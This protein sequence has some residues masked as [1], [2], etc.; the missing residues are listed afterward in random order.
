M[1]TTINNLLLASAF[2]ASM[3][4]CSDFLDK[5]PLSQGTEAIAFQNPSQFQQAA[6]RF[7]EHLPG[8]DYGSMD[9]G[10]DIAGLGSNGGGSAPESNGT[11]GGSYGNIR[12]YNILLEKAEAFKGDKSAL[13]SSVGMAYFFRG[14]A[15][16]NLLRAFGGVPVITDV[17]KITDESLYG[18]RKSRYEVFGQVLS[19]LR[20]A[21]ELLPKESSI[22]NADKGRIS[23]EAA[24]AYLGRVLLYE[25]TWEKYVPS[26]G[27]DLDGDGVEAGAGKAKPS[28]YPSVTDMLTES[29]DMSKA[30]MDEAQ[31]HGTYA[32]WNE[33]DSLSY[34][35]LFSI[36]ETNGNISN[37]KN[38]GK[39]TNKEFIIRRKYDYVLK[40]SRKNITHTVA[41]GQAVQISTQFGE[42]FLCRNGLP[43]RISYTGNM[44]DAQ[45]NPEFSGWGTFIGEFRNR[46]YR[47]IGCTG[48]PD[49]VSWSGRSEDGRQCTVIGQPYPT[50]LFPKNNDKYDP[51]DPVYSSKVAVFRPYLRGGGTFSGYG[52]RKYLPEGA[53]R[54]DYTESADWPILRLA[55]VYLNYAEAVC[56]L[57]NGQ[58]SDQDLDISINKL[59]DRARVAHLTNALIA[60]VW[61]AGWWDHKTNRTVCH[62]MTMLDEIRRERACE[63]FGEGFRMDDLKRWGIAHINLRGLKLGRHVLNTAYTK[64]TCNDATYFGQPCYDPDNAPLRYGLYTGSGS[65]DPDYG[66]SIATVADNLQ[67]LQRDYLSAIPLQQIRLNN[68]LI[69]NP[70]W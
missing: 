31:S 12:Q 17:L 18:P 6:D 41:T 65:N 24:Q 27:Y 19:D 66:R 62:K 53:G 52:S 25:A 9:R 22:A 1:K 23:K 37:F 39:S 11:W 61:D 51:T 35:Y 68:S 63:L 70:G 46:D 40:Q 42:S 2:I 28:G 64:Y 59:R 3:A 4:S 43:L 13:N 55:E 7:I 50:P 14:M 38:V 10:T 69:Q 33:C 26:I 44:S 20:R 45:N 60:N 32:L 49:R 34:Y 29:R 47:F 48:V 15:Y 58:I 21:V 67:Y 16:F 30:V 5:E 36:D 56:E 8:W 57:G 54:P